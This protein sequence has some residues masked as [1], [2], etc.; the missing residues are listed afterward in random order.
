MENIK[1]DEIQKIAIKHAVSGPKNAIITGGAGTG[2]TTIIKAIAEKFREQGIYVDIMAPT[3]KAAARLKE[4]TGF[5]AGTIHR[6]LLW[7]GGAFHR[8][9]N[10]DNPV[11][12]DE[13]SMIDSWLMAAI[14][15]FKPPRLILVGDPAQ[16]PP[17]GKGQPFHDLIRIHPELVCELTTCYRAQGAVHK[18]ASAIRLGDSP[19]KV[20][21]TGGE[22]WRMTET[23]GP[24]ST[25]KQLIAWIRQGFFDPL[26][27]TILATRYGS[28]EEND[29]GIK[30]I[31][32][33]VKAIVNPSTE[34]FAAGDR[35]LINKNFGTDDLWNGDLGVISDIDALGKPWITLDRD[36]GEARL[37]EDKHQKEMSLAYCLSVHKSQGSQFRRVFFAC[38]NSS[39]RMMT[40]SMIYTAVTR[41]QQGV[42]VIGQLRAFYKAI[43]TV[44]DKQT[45]L[46][47]L[48]NETV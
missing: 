30:I 42:C 46:Q 26:Q 47:R 15:K 44:E 13:S 34:T 7:D 9:K 38:F 36:P 45:V 32:Q 19:A 18:A 6:A 2:K 23:G 21:K 24:D 11:I 14:I 33:S 35:I 10:F 25:L 40:R 3:G 43:N 27:D 28:G 16:L 29:G 39:Q 37:L 20:E 5:G 8:F 22:S 4:A 12:V 1:F 41:A 17:V 31:N 48:A